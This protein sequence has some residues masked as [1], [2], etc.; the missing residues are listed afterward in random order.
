MVA[1]LQR[2]NTR[3]DESRHFLKQG[4]GDFLKRKISDFKTICFKKNQKI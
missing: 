2:N 3:R 4:E 1:I